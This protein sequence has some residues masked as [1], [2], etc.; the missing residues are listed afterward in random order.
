MALRNWLNEDLQS[1]RRRLDGGFIGV[2]PADRWRERVDD[3]GIAPVYVIWHTARHHDVAVNAVLRSAPEVLDDWRDR[4]GIVDDTWRGLA[5]GED[6]ELVDQLDSEAVGQ[7]LLAV[8]DSTIAWLADAEL[9][10]AASVPDSLK[11]LRDLGTPEDRF[12][13]L[14]GMWEGKSAHFFLGWEAIGHGYNH[15]GELI[16][17]RNRMGLSP[18]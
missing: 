8:I 14:Y 7:Y 1:L 11:A 9:P 3:G 13:W 18:F 15:L 6:H 5:E 12:D 4:V 10:D 2:V 17:I 16:S